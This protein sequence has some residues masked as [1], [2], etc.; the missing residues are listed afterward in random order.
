MAQGAIPDSLV[1]RL[2]S[3][4]R[5]SVNEQPN[6]FPRYIVIEEVYD[7]EYLAAKRL[8]RIQEKPPN[9]PIEEQ[10]YWMVT[11]F[12]HGRNIYFIQTDAIVFLYYMKDF[13]DNLAKE[14]DKDDG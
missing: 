2:S 9:P 7:T 13:A 6:T 11:G 8:E 12:R 3:Q 5:T 1:A 14:I 10:E 4:S